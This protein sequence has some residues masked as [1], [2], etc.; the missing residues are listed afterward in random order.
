VISIV[1]QSFVAIAAP[2]QSHQLDITHM[3]SEHSHANDLPLQ[4]IN[5]SIDE[6]NISDCHHCGHCSGSHFT[7]IL[8]ENI[9]NS[10]SSLSVNSTPFKKVF[11]TAIF[12]T[13]FRPPRS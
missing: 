8:L 2:A 13:S 9:T 6:H 12:K 5:A 3:Q 1:L 4:T 10:F 7:W 11:P